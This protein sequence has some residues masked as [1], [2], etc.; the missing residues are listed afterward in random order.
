MAMSQ[1][2]APLPAHAIHGGVEATGRRGV[3]S[4]GHPVAAAA[5]LEL[6]AAGGNAVDAA[7]GAAFAAF[8]VEPNNAGIAGYGHLSAF[9]P[10]EGRF[11]TVDHNPRAPRHARADMY[12]LDRAT[13]PE[14]HDWPAVVG[15]RN[16]TGALGPAVPGA[17]SGLWEAHS[18]AGRLPFADVLEP[19]IR[20]A[21][22][23]VEVT[24]NLLLEIVA[25]EEEIRARPH[26]A[27]L[28]LPGGRLPRAATADA[29]G[30]RLDQ[31]ALADILRRIAAE[32]PAAFYRGPVAEAIA[33]EVAAGGGILD[34]DDLAAYAPKVFYEQPQRYRDV[35]LVTS[36]DTVGYEALNIL[37]Q[38][39]L[40]E[41]EPGSAEHLHVLAEAMGHAF[42]DNVTYYGDPDHVESPIAGLTSAAFAAQRAAGIAPDRAAARPIAAADPWPF[43]DHPRPPA[44]VPP[45]SAGGSRGTTQVVAADADG[46]VVALIT[47]I[48]QDFGSLVVVPDT[49]IVLNSSMA[50]FDPRPG[51]S[52]SIAPGK[53]PFFAVPAIVAA[54]EGRGVFAAAGSGGYPILS[55]VLS[56]SVNVLDHGLPVQAAIDAPRVHSQGHRTYVDSRVP[57]AVRARLAE[58]GHELVAQ[59]T[60]P[61]SLAFSRVSAL[62][63]AADGTMAAGS[64]PSWNTAAGAL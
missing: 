12:E 31:S 23:G 64:G 45:P 2:D 61:G 26:A 40:D 13:V 58:L 63:V 52:N 28:L 38:L 30:D 3:V 39:P 57:P 4:A 8:V 59:E 18:R 16:A 15:D 19:A 10:A 50:N 36:N 14:G 56:T 32:G 51:W 25:R 49:A 21:T 53:M 46:N 22:A 1:P 41:I 17:V 9:L 42:A 55:G 11:L 27:A 33:G 35:E 47:T 54:R 24:W 60:S 20:A 29:P 37:A 7:V 43:D 5:G 34:A 62:T 48:G 6:L 44:A